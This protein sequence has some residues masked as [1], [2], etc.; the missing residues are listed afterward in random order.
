M[1]KFSVIIPAAGS[2]SRFHDAYYKKPF[3][4][5]SGRPVWLRTVEHFVH[6][7]DVAEVVLVLAADDLPDF[8]QRFA[9]N[10][11]FM[12][13]QIATGGASRAESVRNGLAALTQTCDFVAVHDA[14]RPLLTPAGISALFAA[15]AE[16]QAVIP[17]IPV[18]STVK[19][20]DS[21]GRI[22][23]TI[24]R[25]ALMLAQT[26]QVFRRDLLESAYAATT[27]ASAFTDEASL[28]E[29]TGVPVFV[30]PGWPI[31]MKITTKED[32]EV[33]EALLSMVE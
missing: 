13:I 32:L 25:S 7:D 27:D 1:P 11:I 10:L 4:S 28:V 29:A 20:V 22:V 23:N 26:P 2:S 15:A 16:K 18:H 24:D 12:P 9:P 5:L 14:A 3:A 21:D 6:R 31:N 8:R 33:A 17:A 19:S 30:H